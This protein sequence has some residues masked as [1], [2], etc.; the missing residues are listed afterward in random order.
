ML[1][2]VIIPTLNEE[3]FIQ[4]AIRSARQGYIPGEVEIIVVDG[5]SRDATLNQIPPDVT[6]LHAQPHRARQMNIGAQLA[7]GEVLAFC[8]ADSRL[9]PGWRAAM[10]AALSQPGVSGGTFQVS[11]L[12]EW[13]IL[14][15]RNRIN[16][17][18]DWRFMYGDQV[19]FM[20][21]QVFEQAGGY[22]ELPILE[23]LE[24]SR[25][26]HRLGRLVRIPLR[27][28]ASSRRFSTAHPCR[29]WLLSIQCVVLYLYF[30]KSA[31]E[32]K[33]L[34]DRGV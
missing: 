22:R 34:Y 33:I 24:M 17:P 14:K 23:D 21:R 12:P 2:S 20:R 30:G 29:Q 10:L 18:P 25:T 3:A 15:L 4:G 13:G 31:E 7:R 32:I 27:V 9:P 19:Q 6:V 8:H 5:G 11:I 1:V 16:Y 26:L 28:Q